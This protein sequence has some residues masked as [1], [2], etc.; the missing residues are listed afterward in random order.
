M[1]SPGA[2]MLALRYVRRIVEDR[3]LEADDSVIIPVAAELAEQIE[4]RSSDS[5]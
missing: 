4:K 2:I 5:K 3:G 1:T